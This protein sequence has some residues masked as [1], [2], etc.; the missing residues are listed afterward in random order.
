MTASILLGDY[1]CLTETLTMNMGFSGFPDYK[2]CCDTHP[3]RQRILSGKRKKWIEKPVCT[4]LEVP[5][6]RNYVE[7]RTARKRLKVQPMFTRVISGQ[8]QE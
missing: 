6:D 3:Q 2:Q 4:S 7:K 1:N 8:N 5:D